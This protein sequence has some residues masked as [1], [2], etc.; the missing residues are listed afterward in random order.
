MVTLSSFDDTFYMTQAAR[1]LAHDRNVAAIAVF[2][3]SGRTALLLSKTRPGVPTLAFTPVKET[4]TRLEMYWGV[5]PYLVPHANTIDEMLKVVEGALIASQTLQPGQQV[6]L[7]CGFPVNEIG[8]T[9]LA[10][11]HTIGER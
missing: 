7:I 4:F 8:P 3:K 10:L 9:N 5:T 11:L 6:V 2:T 1:E